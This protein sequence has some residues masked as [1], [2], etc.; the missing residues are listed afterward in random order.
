MVRACASG[1]Q[2]AD[3]ER[4]LLYFMYGSHGSCHIKMLYLLLKANEKIIKTRGSTY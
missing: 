4:Y 1:I 3:T 2:L